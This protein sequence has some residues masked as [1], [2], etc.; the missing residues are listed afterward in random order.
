MSEELFQERDIS[1]NVSLLLSFS[2][3]NKVSMNWERT[4]LTVFY[5]AGKRRD[6]NNV[7][8]IFFEARMRR[9]F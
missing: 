6:A 2:V 9:R 3:L 8:H 7:K 4:F 5:N 1:R